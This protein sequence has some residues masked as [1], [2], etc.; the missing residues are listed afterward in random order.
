MKGLMQF[1]LGA[2]KRQAADEKRYRCDKSEPTQAYKNLL[3]QID[4]IEKSLNRKA[5]QA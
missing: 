5:Q 1:Y 2:L 4:T 3:R